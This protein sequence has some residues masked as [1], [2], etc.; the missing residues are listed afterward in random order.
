MTPIDSISPQTSMR[1]RRIA[2]ILLIAGLHL[3]VPALLG[4]ESRERFA[5]AYLW[6][7]A[8]LWSVT[9][10]SLFFLGLH[11]LTHARWSVVIR[12]V[13]EMLAA[14]ATGMLAALFIPVVLMLLLHGHFSLF[15]WA[16]AAHVAED[17]IL[18]GKRP[19]LNSPFFLARAALYLAVWAGFTRHFLRQSFR[20]DAGDDAVGAVLRMRRMGAPFMMAFAV[21]VS[22]AAIDWLMSLNPHW[23]STIFGV[24]V[25][26]GM[27]LSGL[28]ALTLA[29][30]ALRNSGRLPEGCVTTDHLYNLGAL[31]FGFSAF[32]AYIAFS[33]YMLIWYANMPE[34]TFY[35]HD[36][37]QG[38]WL[39]VSVALA[40]ARFV[41]PFFLLL[42]RRAKRHARTLVVVSVIVLAGQWLDLFWLI[43]PERHA[44]GP[45]IGW[46]ELG[47]PL[48]LAGALL[49]SLSRFLARRPCLAVGDPLLEESMRFR[50]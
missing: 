44:A 10:G 17:P 23:F 45:V 9:L 49:L 34:E 28:A 35:I 6:G 48:A 31:L 42:P 30:I 13:M 29:V 21:T 7:Y 25:F 26:S 16:D 20:Q 50:L 36:R 37:L 12:R 5:S 3:S 1:L 47:P 4:A 43:M 2:L 39:G 32:W 40:L 14:P 19:Y 38:G 46:Q 18:A 33:Q 11:H 22:F 24:Y 27:A 41:I 8:F 15:P